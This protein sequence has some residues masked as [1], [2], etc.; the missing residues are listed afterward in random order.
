MAHQNGRYYIQFNYAGTR[1]YACRYRSGWKYAAHERGVY[2]KLFA[3]SD[4]AWK[5]IAEIIIPS[6][7][8]APKNPRIQNRRWTL[9]SGQRIKSV[10]VE[11]V[12]L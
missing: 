10:S 11:Y 7:E 3:T 5:V 6:F 4:E 1:R 9:P 12:R 8:R 2:P